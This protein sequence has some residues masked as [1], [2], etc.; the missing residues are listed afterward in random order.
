M[1]RGR[2]SM[3]HQVTEVLR[4]AAGGLSLR[5]ISRS[6]RIG[7]TTAREYLERAR[8]AGLSWPLP[9]ELTEADLEARLY[10]SPA[11]S[12]GP[13]PLP[14]WLAVHRDLKR[15]KHV[16]LKLLWLEY[17]DVHPDGLGYSQ[18]SDRYRQW[19]T[20]RLHRP[21]RYRSRPAWRVS[22]HVWARGP[23][24]RADD[25]SLETWPAHG[26][27]GPSVSCSSV[28]WAACTSVTRSSPCMQN[29]L[30]AKRRHGRRHP[31]RSHGLR[32]GGRHPCP[33]G[34]WKTE[35]PTHANTRAS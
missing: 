25:R 29:D 23:A 18:F 6:L 22:G 15:S 32:P 35:L 16:T 31:R 8:R 33:V 34:L 30:G 14:D 9:P 28:Q 19:A 17:R 20:V 4:L 24:Q 27:Q 10:T 5:E 3:R 2:L 26:R 7:H 13:R 1:P 21:T 11:T 12:A